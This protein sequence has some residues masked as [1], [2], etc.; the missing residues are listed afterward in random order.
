MASTPQPPQ[1]AESKR[2]VDPSSVRMVEQDTVQ[3]EFLIDDLIK[4]LMREPI[5]QV[6]SCNGCSRC[7]AVADLPTTP[8]ERK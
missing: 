2:A 4:E 7:A 5:V 3:V 1:N 8:S 6:A